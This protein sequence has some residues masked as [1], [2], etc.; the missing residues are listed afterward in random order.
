LGKQQNEKSL[1]REEVRQASENDP[2]SGGGDRWSIAAF[3]EEVNRCDKYD[4]IAA[5]HQNQ[6]KSY[7]AQQLPEVSAPWRRVRGTAD[8]IAG[9]EG[10]GT[11]NE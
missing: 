8:Q 11:K 3:R 7:A 9:N 2:R 5:S 6:V 10:R 4:F 1:P